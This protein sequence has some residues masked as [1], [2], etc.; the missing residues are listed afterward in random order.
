MSA[1]GGTSRRI[2]DTSRS[3]AERS[4]WLPRCST[5]LASSFAS[6]V[7][8]LATSAC[9]AASRSAIRSASRMKR[10]GRPRQS[11]IASHNRSIR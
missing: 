3:N 11:L 10:V 2:R 9:D 8:R 4:A 6:P 1:A 7:S 5:P